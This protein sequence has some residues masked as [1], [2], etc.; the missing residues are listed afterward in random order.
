MVVRRSMKHLAMWVGAA[1]AGSVSLSASAAEFRVD[2]LGD[3]H[4]LTPG[5]GFCRAVLI[6]GEPKC[7]LR[8]AIEEANA[9][10]GDDV[11]VV[12]EATYVLTL[13]Q[14]LITQSVDILGEGMPVIDANHSSRVFD[15]TE[16]RTEVQVLFRSLTI[17][18]GE[19][20]VAGH[21][22]AGLVVRSGAHVELNR[23]R[24][25]HNEA[26][27]GGAGIWNEGYLRV[28]RSSIRDNTN[29]DDGLGGG[30]NARG[31]GILNGVG[32]ELFVE[33]SA[34]VRNFAIRAGGI[35][36]DHYA[37]IRDSTI[38]GNAALN[39]GAGIHNTSDGTMHIERCTITANEVTF[40]LGEDAYAGGGGIA[41][42]G[43]LTLYTSIVA[44]N[45]DPGDNPSFPYSPDCAN[46][47][48][49]TITSLGHNLIG[50]TRGCSYIG[51]LHDLVGGARG[52]LDPELGPLSIVG[53]SG[54]E[55]RVPL[56]GSPVLHAGPR[57]LLPS[58]PSSPIPS[59][60]LV[61]QRGY[62]R[63]NG[64][65]AEIDIGAYEVDGT[66]PPFI[67]P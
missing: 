13:G 39:Y 9:L 58:V 43:V 66:P 5:D 45:V 8:A 48:G 7:T 33:E 34:V 17:R 41:N 40:G 42:H 49:A 23:C 12:A 46:F 6:I 26:I 16:L 63:A 20:T 53:A 18:N 38:S 60:H 61:D 15:V 24:V 56:T 1:L 51:G 47:D 57:C 19:M 3:L 31:G 22:G 36:N 50:D 65:P 62:V 10:P 67:V 55:Q 2:R 35:F 37:S 32:A 25:E 54:T 11:I 59:C 29:T 28:F 14:L 44:E 27:G 30:A 4:V 52:V 21:G 64:T